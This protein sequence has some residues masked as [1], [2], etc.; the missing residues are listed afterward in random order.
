MSRPRFAFVLLTFLFVISHLALGADCVAPFGNAVTLRAEATA[1]RA[2]DLTYI[3]IANGF[4]Y[5]TVVLELFSRRVIGWA[6]STHIDAELALG[7]LRQAI[8]TRQPPLG[9]VHHS[10]RR[11]IPLQGLR[12]TAERASLRDLQFG[13]GQPIPQRLRRELHEDAETRGVY[14]ANYETY[15]DVLENL[16]SFIEEVHNE[17]RVHSGIDYLTPSELEEKIKL[18]PTLAS[19]FVL[20][21]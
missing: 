17:K 2:G 15:L 12:R 13:Q 20:Q 10:D 21:L 8:Q 14:L 7:A 19:R 9:C 1:S 18:D 11:A 4:V 16:P 3:R 5:L 6:I